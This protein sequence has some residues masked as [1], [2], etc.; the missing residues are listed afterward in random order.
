MID[1][2][3]Q[4]PSSPPEGSFH[5]N[6][7]VHRGDPKMDTSSLI[8]EVN[9]M[10]QGDLDKLRKKYSFPPGVQI[11][12]LEKGETILSTRPGEMAFYEASFLADLRFPMHPIIRRILNHYKL[13]PTQLSPN[14]WRC[15][16]C[17]LVI[18]RYYKHHISYN[19]F[20][21]MYSLNPLPDSGWF[22]FKAR[23]DK[24]LLKGL[25]S[26]MKGGRRGSSLPQKMNG[27]FFF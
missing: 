12:I 9:I 20:R 15:V 1:N 21:C 4:S 5:G 6:S 2:V 23:L 13:C 7:P 11:R 22:Y 18:W 16:V 26:N 14:V 8:K 3:N 27:S 24:N 25:P 19:E 17:S 10:T